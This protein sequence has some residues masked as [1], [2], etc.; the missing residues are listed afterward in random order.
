MIFILP[1]VNLVYCMDLFA[2]IEPSLCPW[3]KF[4]LITVYDPFYILLDLVC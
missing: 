2:N 3:N 1:F 4:H